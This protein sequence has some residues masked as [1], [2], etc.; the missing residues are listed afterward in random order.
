MGTLEL[1]IITLKSGECYCTDPCY[2]PGTWCHHLIK[3]KPGKYVVG[4]EGA[5]NLTDRGDELWIMLEGT[6]YTKLRFQ[7]TMSCGVDSGTVA[8]WDKE[9][10]QKFH[11]NKEEW[12]DE[13]C[14]DL[15][16]DDKCTYK[17]EHGC[18]RSTKWGDGDYPLTLG[19]N[20]DNEC[21]YASILHND[22]SEEYFD[23]EDDEIWDEE[24]E[25][26][27]QEEN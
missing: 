5:K 6:D 23:D 24:E 15:L 1:G 12:W 13:V 16:D 19:F 20:E 9:E 11:E 2:E 7:Q 17:T 14:K 3:M 18:A 10:Y 8:F 26:Y 4:E 22:V 21:V 27:D 25:E